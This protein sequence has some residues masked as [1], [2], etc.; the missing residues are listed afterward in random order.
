[1]NSEVYK[2]IRSTQIQPKRWKTEMDSTS[3]YKRKMT[4][5]RKTRRWKEVSEENKHKQTGAMR[6]VELPVI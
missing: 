1:M 3:Q 4:K 6:C 2:A 5:R